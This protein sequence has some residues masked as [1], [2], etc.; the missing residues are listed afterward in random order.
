MRTLHAACVQIT[1]EREEA[2]TIATT[3]DLIRAARAKGAFYIQTPECTSMIEPDKKR[4]LA[5]AHPES[6]HPALLAFQALAQE[7]VIWLHIGSLVV[8]LQDQG[9]ETAPRQ[10]KAANRS[11][12]IAPSGKISA[13]YDK[14]HMFDVALPDG[15]SYRESATFAAGDQA[16]VTDIVL[17]DQKTCSIGLSICY[18][19]RFGALYRSLATAGAEILTAPAAFTRFTGQAHWSVLQR[20]RAIENGCFVVS[21]AQCGTHAQGRET[22]GHAIII[23]PWG[24]VLAEAGNDPCVITAELDLSHVQQ[25][26]N[27]VPSLQHNRPFAHP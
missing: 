24:E 5:K 15:Q 22:Y 7:L 26:R 3:I 27:M 17:P 21:A 6:A 11:F 23:A 25:A 13:R 14:I 12:V 9:S 2:P 1:A 16:V 18:D 8:G 4:L 10:R 19:I 20:A